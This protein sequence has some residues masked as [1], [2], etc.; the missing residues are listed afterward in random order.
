MDYLPDGIPWEKGKPLPV[1]PGDVVYRVDRDNGF[2]IVCENVYEVDVCVHVCHIIFEG[3]K[4]GMKTDPKFEELDCY[5]FP[6]KESAEKWI[7]DHEKCGP[8]PLDEA[9]E[10]MDPE[11]FLPADD[12]EKVYVKVQ[13]DFGVFKMDAFYVSIPEFSGFWSVVDQEARKLENVIAW[14]S[15]AKW[16]PETNE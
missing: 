1:L 2:K 4:M 6:D 13:T 14:I 8:W 15:S 11:Q 10:W 9:T 5:F 7:A 12:N 3:C 16:D